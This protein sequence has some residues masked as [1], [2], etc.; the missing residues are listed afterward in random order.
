MNS[1]RARIAHAD[2]LL[3]L[4]LLLGTVVCGALLVR[5]G[6][7]ALDVALLRWF[8]S[9]ADSARLAGPEWLAATWLGLTWLGDVI[10]RLAVSVLT[11]FALLWLRRWHSALFL[12]AVLLSGIALST[13]IKDAVGRPRPQLVDQ[14]DVVHS[15]SFPSGHALN[16]ALFYLMTARLLAPGLRRRG[17]RRTIY[18]AAVAL[19]LAI[20]VSRVALG[21]HWPSDVLASWVICGA[22]LWLWFGLAARHWPAVLR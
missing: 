11:A 12:V 15:A 16:S 20:G 3:P 8:R 17:L 1:G 19:S 7:G 6:P 14:L 10:P 2:W 4:L 5:H 13:A 9:D 18:V 21:V 22:W